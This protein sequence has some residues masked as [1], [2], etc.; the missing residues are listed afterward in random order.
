M[1]R[2]LLLSLAVVATAVVII[3]P[4]GDFPLNDD[5][6]YGSAVKGLVEQ[7]VYRLSDWTAMPLFTQAM[8]GSL[9]CLPTGF[10]FTALRFSTLAMSLLALVFLLLML[11]RT[12]ETRTSVLLTGGLILLFNPIWLGLSH[13]FMTDVHFI[14]LA[15]VSLYLLALGM[16][17]RN[18]LA[19]AGG[20]LFALLATLVRQ[21]GILIPVAFGFGYLSQRQPRP[22]QLGLAIGFLV[23][24]VGGYLAYSRILADTVGT[25]VI[26]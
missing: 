21:T 23:L 19:L 15:L 16:E 26:A 10:S 18:R 5:W 9:F 20:I 22:W 6:S 8:W 12:G 11:R 3:N 4:V 2:T 25:D 1:T 13:T 7:G 17:S 14:A 24:V